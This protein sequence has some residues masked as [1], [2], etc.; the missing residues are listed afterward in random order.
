MRSLIPE[1]RFIEVHVDVDI[2]TAKQ[3]DPKGL[4][5]KVERGEIEEFTGIGSP[6]EV[7]ENPELRLRTADMAIE[8]AVGLVRASLVDRG[9]IPG[10]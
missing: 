10:A 9:I 7:P 5:A 1:G 2:E 8:E 4:Y 3:R 6:Y